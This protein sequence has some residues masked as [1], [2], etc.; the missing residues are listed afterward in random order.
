MTH[1]KPSGSGSLSTIGILAYVLI[2]L[3]IAGCHVA[4]ALAFTPE[5][6][7]A[8]AAVLYVALAVWCFLS[9][10]SGH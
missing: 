4:Q 10:G 8:V 7:E 5:P 2:Y 1:E 6:W 9:G 3:G